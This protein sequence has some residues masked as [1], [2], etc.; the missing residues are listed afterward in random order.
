MVFSGP[1]IGFYNII[2]QGK[3]EK[4]NITNNKEVVLPNIYVYLKC[5]FSE[6]LC[7]PTA[8]KRITSINI[9]TQLPG[10]A[11]TLLRQ[12]DKVVEESKILQQKSILFEKT[13]FNQNIY[14]LLYTLILD[15]MDI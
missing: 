6:K 7:A 14:Y 13:H 10:V 5:N 3:A 2:F 11:D 1:D 4:H 12:C 8:R 9:F 15:I